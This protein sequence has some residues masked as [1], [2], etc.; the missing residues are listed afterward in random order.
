MSAEGNGR[1]RGDGRLRCLIVDDNARFIDAARRM[2]EHD[3][4]TVVGAAT[5][6]AKART[7]MV[8]LRPDVVLVD[9]FLGQ[10]NGFEFI[11]EINRTGTGDHA[12]MVLCS[13]WPEDDLHG[14]IDGH[15]R[16]HPVPFVPK[17]KLSGG[18]LRDIVHA[19]RA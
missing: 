5:N 9:L 16:G 6:G 3:G 17:T 14:L 13:S 18:A 12:V 4:L 15:I 19:R 11:T 7:L 1:A 8:K 2:L 10:E